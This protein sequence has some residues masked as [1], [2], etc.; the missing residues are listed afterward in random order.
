M[1]NTNKNVIFVDG[2]ERYNKTIIMIIGV[3]L[4]NFKCFKGLHYVPLTNA[5]G[6]NFCGLIGLNGVGKS[7]V[8]EALDC[9]FN[10]K[11]LNPSIGISPVKDD[12]TE[13]IPI[14][15]VEKEFETS[16]KKKNYVKILKNV[17]ETFKDFIKSDNWLITSKHQNIFNEIKIHFNSFPTPEKEIL[18]LYTSSNIDGIHRLILGIQMLGKDFCSDLMNLSEQYI[19]SYIYVYL[20]NSIASEDFAIFE[21]EQILRLLDVDFNDINHNILLRHSIRFK[22]KINNLSRNL[23]K[24]NIT[25]MSSNDD[26]HIDEREFYKFISKKFPQYQITKRINNIDVPLAQSSS[27]EKKQA[28]M[29]LIAQITIERKRETFFP[30]FQK[31]L[32]SNLII[33]ID[34]PETSFHISERFEQFHKLYEISKKSNQVLFTS[35]WFGFIPSIPEGCVVNIVKNNDEF[36]FAPIDIYKY[37]EEIHRLKMPIDISLK[38]NLDLIQTIVSSV[39]IG[40]CYNWLICEG[41]SDKIYLEEYLNDEI[42]DL[43]LRIIPAGGCANIK[44]IHDYLALTLVELKNDL[45]G[46]VYLL[47]D[48]DENTKYEKPTLDTNKVKQYLCFKRLVNNRQENKT[49]LEDYGSTLNYPTDI[50]GVLNGKAFNVALNRF[51]E[52]LPFVT[53]DEKPEIPSAFALDL[54]GSEKDALKKFFSPSNKVRFARAYVEEIKKRKDCYSV[55]SW[56][57]DIKKF[58]TS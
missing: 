6:S 48:T 23:S 32:K 19:N 13:V 1:S 27:G 22:N 15:I 11:T 45:K 42:A 58:F 5:N 44:K 14:C 36:T 33:A 56:I 35:H 3:I 47:V 4:N 17:S 37:K 8:L 12:F 20:P 24:Y 43:K 53:E 46:K 57:E 18:P 40:N 25:P 28:I 38:G 55:P 41:A 50:E 29:D 30:L 39:L 54:R 52:E 2:N 49:F 21:T 51:K 31:Q 34:E 9:V 7:A 10:G 26:F 16:L